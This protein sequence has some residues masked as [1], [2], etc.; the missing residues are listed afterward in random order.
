MAGEGDIDILHRDIFVYAGFTMGFYP[1]E[2]AFA[3]DLP[4]FEW[5]SAKWIGAVRRIDR[6]YS[7]RSTRYSNA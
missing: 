2:L 7:R 3:R 4:S 6:G 5:L 1:I